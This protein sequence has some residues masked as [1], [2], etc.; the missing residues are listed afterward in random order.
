MR[1]VEFEIRDLQM[2]RLS[3]FVLRMSP[4]CAVLALA[5][6]AGCSANEWVTVRSTPHSPLVERLKL[7]GRG[8][9]EPSERSVQ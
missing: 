5:L 4:C 6:L 8:G 9:G 1:N 3:S 2:R 7:T